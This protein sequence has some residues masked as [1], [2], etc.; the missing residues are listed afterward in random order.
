[1]ILSSDRLQ[2][3]VAEPGHPPNIT[4]RF[5][6]SC[7]ITSV[8]LD[9]Q[10]E[11][12]TREPDNLSHPSSG[13]YGLCHEF[14][15]SQMCEETVANGYFP[16]PGIGLMKKKGDA[17]YYF[18]EPYEIIPFPVTWKQT[19]DS[20]FFYMTAVSMDGY[21]WEQ[22]RQLSVWENQLTIRTTLKN[23]GRKKLNAK[24]YCHNFLTLQRF[25]LGNEYHIKLPGI[26]QQKHD[27]LTGTLQGEDGGITFSGY[28][29]HSALYS[30]SQ[31]DIRHCDSFSWEMIHSASEVWIK[32]VDSFCPCQV[33]IWCIDHLI[34]VEVFYPIHLSTGEEITWE[35]TWEF[36][37]H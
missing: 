28:N 32:G 30:I 24:E 2:V 18:Y 36:G 8:L 21:S 31:E 34:S 10:F 19:S 26:L 5:D 14:V 7:F 17:P 13:G 33:D 6:R 12:C 37:R 1:M 29:P 23:T 16:K 20:A 15:A 35:R 3:T 11:F 22:T 25:P 4:S 27:I 9:G